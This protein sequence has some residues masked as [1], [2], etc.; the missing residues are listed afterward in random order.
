MAFPAGTRR[1]ARGNDP[2]RPSGGRPRLVARTEHEGRT[3]RRLTRIPS[4][5][6]CPA[7]RS[8]SQ[9]RCPALRAWSNRRRYPVPR[10]GNA[11]SSSMPSP[12]S[13]IVW[14]QNTARELPEARMSE[15][16]LVPAALAP[17]RGHGSEPDGLARFP[18]AQRERCKV[19]DAVPNGWSRL[20]P[21]APGSSDHEDSTHLLRR[22]TGR[23]LKPNTASRRS[24]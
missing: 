4:L 23:W 3:C 19:S 22:R 14:K 1:D 13:W 8:S 6:P 24:G 17:C 21:S 16:A 12:T 20:V 15:P 7:H 2:H 9:T 5:S 11:P 10:P 18:H